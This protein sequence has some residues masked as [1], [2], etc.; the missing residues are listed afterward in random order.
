MEVQDISGLSL[1]QL[2][3]IKVSVATLKPQN[4]SK[5]PGSVT[6]FT[7]QQLNDLGVETL[8]DLLSNV[9]G[10]YSMLNAAEGNQSYLV[11]RGH[12][13][14]YA[15]TLLILHNGK[16]L[17]DDYTGGINYL[18]RYMSLHNADRVEIIRGAGSALYGSNAFSGVVNIVT[19]N[20]PHVRLSAGENSGFQTD[21]GAT[22][23]VGASELGLS[24]T[25]Y[26]D[27][28]ETYSPIFDR[29]GIQNATND[30]KDMLQL[31]LNLDLDKTQLSAFHLE[32]DRHNYYLFRR[33]RDGQTHIHLKQSV[34]GVSHDLYST[35]YWQIDIGADSQNA[36]RRT[37][38]ALIPQGRD[39]FNDA[40]FLFGE[41]LIYQSNR[42]YGNAVY[43]FEEH[44]DLS[45]GTEIVQSEVPQ[46]FLRSNYNLF[47]NL[48]YLGE[49]V[50]FDDDEQRV[51]LDKKRKI[52][53]IYGQWQ[54]PINKQWEITF[55]LR[56]DHYNDI[57]SALMPRLALVYQQSSNHIFKWMYAEAYRAPS[58][59]DLYD[60]ESGLTV[61]N[62][63]LA[64]TELT[65]LEFKYQWISDHTTI[66]ASLFQNEMRDLIGFRSDANNNVFLGNIAE[67][68]SLGIELE[69]RWNFNQ[70]LNFN[71][72]L[73]HLF[74]NK[75]EQT[76]AGEF[77]S[78]KILAPKTIAKSHMNWS[79]N[80]E[81]KWSLLASW[82]SEVEI[83]SD[84]SSL[85]LLNS[86]LGYQISEKLKLNFAVKN[87]LDKE[88]QTGSA[89]ALG[90]FSGNTVQQYPARG[91]EIWLRASYVF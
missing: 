89:V 6:L 7:R 5:T 40:D 84:S 21:V 55:G 62:Q 34:F 18:N 17:N 47:G 70:S 36:K 88:Y 56:Y 57:D 59:G 65:S 52:Y 69:W 67:N 24:F 74:D 23:Q 63:S 87:L 41:H 77:T 33:V 20:T 81:L 66:I 86:N 37:I 43:H 28:G 73:T 10:F 68:E 58:L 15:N 25:H 16:R 35:D 14:K 72:S 48:E 54:K 13:Q 27:K 22:T 61:G 76:M 71:S 12:P 1:R 53:S 82:R 9:P 51:V 42:V 90:N 46:S 44:G 4:L 19:K 29:F 91:R 8:A 3:N 26:S 50:K 83:L 85:L 64:A 32:S 80:E 11:M 75:T 38:T 78:S 49:I 60:E 79:I 45:F 30:P 39:G 2:L 31:E